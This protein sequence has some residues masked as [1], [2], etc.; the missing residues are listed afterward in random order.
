MKILIVDDC[1]DAAIIVSRVLEGD[2][3]TFALLNSKEEAQKYMRSNGLPDVL[4]TDNKMEYDT[5]G[6]D[7]IAESRNA[8]YRGAILLF[9]SDELND[10]CSLSLFS[11]AATYLRKPADRDVINACFLLACRVADRCFRY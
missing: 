1:P 3:R 5:A 9:T 10:R 11:Y 6:L 7:L 8:G 2:G 4:I